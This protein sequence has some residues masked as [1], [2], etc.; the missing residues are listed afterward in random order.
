ME[1]PTTL[2]LHQIRFGIDQAGRHYR[3]FEDAQGLGVRMTHTDRGAQALQPPQPPTPSLSD[4]SGSAVRVQIISP[5]DTMSWVLDALP[6]RHFHNYEML[7]AA[8]AGLSVADVEAV[9]SSYPRVINPR[10]YGISSGQAQA[11]YMPWCCLC[12]MPLKAV[13]DPLNHPPPLEHAGALTVHL[14]MQWFDI[15]GFVLCPKHALEYSR[16]P[17]DLF[18][19]AL[20]EDAAREMRRRAFSPSGS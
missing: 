1:L 4:A 2:R 19:A 13:R 14:A 8:A 20:A 16:K 11:P 15:R 17:L 5:F 9:R 7:R 12:H 3:V 6:N 10:E 18:G